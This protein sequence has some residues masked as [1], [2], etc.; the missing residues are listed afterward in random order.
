MLGGFVLPSVLGN[1]F[2]GVLLVAPLNHSQVAADQE[3][4]RV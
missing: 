4:A 3:H 1:A 2:G